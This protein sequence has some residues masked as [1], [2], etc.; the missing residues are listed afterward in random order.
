MHG[1]RLVSLVALTLATAL[2]FLPTPA[3]AFDPRAYNSLEAR[4]ARAHSQGEN[5]QFDPRDGWQTVNASNLQYKYSR[6]YGDPD[7]VDDWD[8][9]A[10]GSDTLE[11]RSSKKSNSTSKSTKNTKSKA[12]SKSKSINPKSAAA[13]VASSFKK[14]VDSMKGTGKAEPVTIT[15]YTGHDLENPSCWSNPTW[16]PSVRRLQS[17]DCAPTDWR[18]GRVFRLRFDSRWLDR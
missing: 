14:I 15:W 4:D 17:S 10:E 9:G 3:S 18:A 8:D 13:K 2:A 6:D 12:K 1:F 11:K 5:Y 16:A 7:D